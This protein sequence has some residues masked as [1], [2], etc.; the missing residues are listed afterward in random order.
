M[1]VFLKKKH[2]KD[3]EELLNQIAEVYADF[4]YP[5]DMDSFINYLPSKDNLQSKY[6]KEENIT[7]LINLFNEFLNK[8]HKYLQN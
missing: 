1:L 2:Q 6:S 5:E 4:N 8:E 7:R 3:F